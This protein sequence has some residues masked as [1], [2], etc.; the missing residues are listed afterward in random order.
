MDV[1]PSTTLS[2]EERI[3]LLLQIQAADN[4]IKWCDWLKDLTQMIPGSNSDTDFQFRMKLQLLSRNCILVKNVVCILLM[5]RPNTNSTEISPALKMF[6]KLHKC[7][8][9]IDC[10]VRA[11]AVLLNEKILKIKKINEDQVRHALKEFGTFYFT[12]MVCW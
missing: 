10:C 7:N 5:L 11:V 8:D 3:A 12:K 2:N 4:P 6:Y 9:D 1:P